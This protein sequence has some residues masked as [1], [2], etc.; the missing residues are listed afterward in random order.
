MYLIYF[1]QV[2]KSRARKSKK[3]SG[4]KVVNDEK[5]KP[6]ESIDSRKDVGIL[7]TGWEIV[8]DD[9]LDNGWEIIDEL[10]YDDD[11][12]LKIDKKLK[13]KMKKVSEN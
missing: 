3:K 6:E 11:R 9:D 2:M 4:K 1:M 5:S 13:M 8:S 12:Y 10:E 7:D